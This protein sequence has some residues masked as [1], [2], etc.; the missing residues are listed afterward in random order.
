M[1]TPIR[2]TSGKP[3]SYVEVRYGGQ[4]FRTKVVDDSEDPAYNEDIVS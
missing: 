4:S 3:D 2:N 1:D